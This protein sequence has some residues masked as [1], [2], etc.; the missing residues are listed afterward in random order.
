MAKGLKVCSTPGCPTL[1][2]QGRCEPC[3][4]KAE[5]R[6]GTSAQRGYGRRHRDRFR[7]GVL[8]KNPVCVICRNAPSTVADHYPLD[9]RQLVAKSLDPD[10]PIY[11]RGLCAPCDSAQTALRQPGGWNA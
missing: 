7:K 6:R 2:A 10:D 1:V 4:A 5:K 11:G 9:R 8:D 3:K